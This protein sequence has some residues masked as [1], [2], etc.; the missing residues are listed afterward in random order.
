[1]LG[2]EVILALA[3]RLI[4]SALALKAVALAPWQVQI[5]G[6]VP[7]DW[8]LNCQCETCNIIC[9]PAT[10][11][12]IVTWIVNFWHNNIAICGLEPIGLINICD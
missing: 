9:A 7:D 11:S 3:F 5:S 12:D 8:Q 4:S 1:M 6:A 10:V 2:P